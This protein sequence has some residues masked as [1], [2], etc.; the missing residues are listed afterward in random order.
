MVMNNRQKAE[1]RR[2]FRLV[3]F[4]NSIIFVTTLILTHAIV[5]SDIK[6]WA[7]RE[8]IGP[9]PISLLAVGV[10]FGLSIAFSFFVSQYWLLLPS[11][12]AA[13]VMPLILYQGIEAGPFDLRQVKEQ[14]DMIQQKHQYF[15]G[16][17]DRL[18]THF[19]ELIEQAPRGAF[20]REAGRVDG[21][22]DQYLVHVL[23]PSAL[24]GAVHQVGYYDAKQHRLSELRSPD[25]LW[26]EWYSTSKEAEPK[27]IRSLM[28]GHFE[29][30]EWAYATSRPGGTFH[31]KLA[32]DDR[33][34]FI[35]DMHFEKTNTFDR[36][37]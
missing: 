18:E 33:G 20:V 1:D 17:P 10:A 2:E 23:V 36:K 5:L 21:S 16:Q 9:L 7:F 12:L 4:F 34:V 29:K 11:L 24:F 32:V 22:E 37:P 28:E 19:P 3:A 27:R 30:G 14:Q 15:G 8:I 31:A 25:E 35:S 26:D 13:A 6:Y